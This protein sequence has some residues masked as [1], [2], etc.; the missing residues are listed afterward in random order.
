MIQPWDCLKKEHLLQTSIFTVNQYDCRRPKDGQEGRFFSIDCSDWVHVLAV[1][2]DHH[3]IF[4][5][6]FRFG[7]QDFSWE[8]PGGM[9]DAGEAPIQAAIREL[10]EETGYVG[11]NPQL[12]ASFSP[13]PALMSNR[14]HVVF[15]ESVEPVFS[16]QWDE[17][18]HM[19]IQAVPVEKVWDWVQSGQITHAIVLAALLHLKLR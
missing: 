10:R 7:N 14:S 15:I 18:E 16:P 9:I 5:K 2:A 19:E 1:S 13:N 3:L 17:H 6:Q 11:H 12:L 8:I 4:V